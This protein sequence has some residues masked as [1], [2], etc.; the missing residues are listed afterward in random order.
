MVMKT[1]FFRFPEQSLNPY[2]CKIFYPYKPCTY[3]EN[4]IYP[5]LMQEIRHKNLDTPQAQ[6]F[7]NFLALPFKKLASCSWL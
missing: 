1:G 7:C 5:D 2:W 3:W 6:Q 4:L